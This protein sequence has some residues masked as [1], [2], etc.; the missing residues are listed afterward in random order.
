[1]EQKPQ[2]WIYFYP[3]DYG[4]LLND[5]YRN[6]FIGE[7]FK[8][9]IRSVLEN[10]TPMFVSNMTT[11][12][13]NRNNRNI[14]AKKLQARKYNDS[15]LFSKRNKMPPPNSRPTISEVLEFAE[16]IG[17]KYAHG[18]FELSEANNWAD[19]YGKPIRNWKRA[20]VLYEA[21]RNDTFTIS[22]EKKV[23]GEYV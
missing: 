15:F 11:L 1:M 22:E 8:D 6:D 21:M 4:H 12:G 7:I 18:W 13:K 2:R 16:S 3:D 20:L 9:L 23:G 10:K 14:C 19:L 5:K 17:A